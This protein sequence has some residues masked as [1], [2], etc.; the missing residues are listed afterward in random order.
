MTDLPVT[1]AWR[2]G[3]PPGDRQFAAIG[4]MP[5]EWAPPLA[6]VVLAYET[7]GTFT[8]DNAV[9]VEHALTGDAHVV[10]EPGPGQVTGGWWEGL[11]GP[12]L[13]L[14]TDRWFV[15]A[16]N[17]LGGCGGSTGPSSP[18]ADGTALGSRFP[19]TTIRDQVAAE[20][21]LAA[22]LGIER[23]ALVLGGSMGG[24]R[25]VEWAVM[26]PS[27][28]QRLLLLA[29]GA[30]ATAEQI[31]L[32]AAQIAAIKADPHWH[33]GDYY[34]EPDGPV[35]G[36]G[37]ARRIAHISYRGTR[38][39]ERR[40]G[41]SPQEGE[42]PEQGGRYAIESYLDHHA[43]KLARRFDAGSYVVLSEA[44]NSHDVGRD[45][46]GI[47]A[48]L[49]E[50]T[51]RTAVLSIDSDR[52]YWPGQQSELAQGIAGARLVT[53]SSP[54]GHDGFLLEIDAVSATV[55]GLLD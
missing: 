45:R 22:A 15:V 17:V 5:L 42:S 39:L 1:G 26:A 46:G 43:A 30:S 11:I 12:G 35:I 31:A 34:D 32:C 7:W 51:A 18:G 28:V 40:F 3:D 48:A 25:A 16:P 24:M 55:R 50:I 21:Q 52:L 10:G 6:D 54:Y 2:V 53:V 33:G 19:R 23:W 44:M 38:E 4:T 49:G 36:M 13:A 20:L 27:S 47:A 9:L 37:I 14:D 29:T 41:R 8:G